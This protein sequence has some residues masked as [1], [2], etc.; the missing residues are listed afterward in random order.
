[1][2]DL[3]PMETKSGF[4]LRI[5]EENPSPASPTISSLESA[6]ETVRLIQHLQNKLETEHKEEMT[7][8]KA[9]RRKQYLRDY[10][11][12]YYEQHRDE[13]LEKA[14]Q[15]YRDKRSQN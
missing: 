10:S 7:M 1:M 14:K 13:L 3:S 9:E 8:M 5:V 4:V 6:L 2:S 12:Q 11:R 15:K